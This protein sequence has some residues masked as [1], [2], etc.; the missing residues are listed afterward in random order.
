MVISAVNCPSKT[1]KTTR[2]LGIDG[3]V[4]D[5]WTLANLC[6][7]NLSSSDVRNEVSH[8]LGLSPS[9]VR[10]R[11]PYVGGGFGGKSDVTIEP[12]LAYVASQV[13][14]RYIK[15]V[16]TREE[17]FEGTVLGR[18]AFAHYKTGFSRDGR[19]LAQLHT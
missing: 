10:V 8:L 6:S 19:V 17:M 7:F 3:W 12:L 1:W 2:A 11:V 16:L 15:L 4:T 9:K 14:G 13:P 18:G 5:L